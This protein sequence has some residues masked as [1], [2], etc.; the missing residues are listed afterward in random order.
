[1]KK[2]LNLVA[3][4][5]ILTAACLLIPWEHVNW[6]KIAI[7]P[8]STITVTGEAKQDVQNQIARFSAGVTVINPDKQTA[9]NE[10]NTKMTKIIK[11]VKDFGINDKDIQTQTVSVNQEEEPVFAKT[12]WRATNNIDIV[13]RNIDQASALTDLLQSLQATNVYGPSFSVDDTSE[14][15]TAL[16]Q[17]AIDDAREKAGIIAKASHRQLGKVLTVTEGGVS[18]PGPIFR[19]AAEPASSTPVEPGSAQVYQSVTVTFELK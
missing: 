12:Q 9:I 5:A 7:L 19:M 11:A 14:T 8:A 16:L 1:M 17:A 2:F 10:V 13:L 15:E 6:G 3:I 4:I 18:L